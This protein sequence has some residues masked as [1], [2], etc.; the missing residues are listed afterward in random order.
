MI[1]V[2]ARIE[3]KAEC[4]EGFLKE[5]HRIVPRVR[6]EQGCLAYG[7]TVDARTDLAAQVPL[8]EN[9]VAIVEQWESLDAL[10]RHLAA[11]HMSEYRARVKDLVAKTAVHVLEPA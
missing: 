2:I 8:G 1:H 11:P 3:V 7:P 9:V 4:R 6:A 5:F 10:K